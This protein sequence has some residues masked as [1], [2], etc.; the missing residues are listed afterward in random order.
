MGGV[1]TILNPKLPIFPVSE[2][3]SEREV[4]KTGVNLDIEPPFGPEDPKYLFHNLTWL[5]TVMEDAVRI[6]VVE[7][8]V[9]KRETP[10]VA[11]YH[12]R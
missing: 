6:H 3:R 9:R 12:R 8:G 1:S 11:L 10:P 2:Q 4:G 7:G 5:I